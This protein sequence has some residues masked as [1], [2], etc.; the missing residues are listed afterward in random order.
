MSSS[1]IRGDILR[2]RTIE[3][4]T[5]TESQYS[6][7]SHL[8]VHEHA[9]AYFCL[10]LAGKYQE[11]SGR[12]TYLCN[13]GSLVVHPA[14]EKHRNQ[15]DVQ[16]VRC[17][18]LELAGPSALK[19]QE[20]RV[21]SA[22]AVHNGGPSAFAL[23]RIYREFGQQDAAAE[24]IIQGLMLELFG[25]CQRAESGRAAGAVPDSARQCRD[26]LCARFQDR[27]SINEIARCVDVHPVH[28]CRAFYSCYGRTIGEFVRELRVRWAAEQLASA[29]RPLVTI[30]IEAGFCDQSHFN[31][32][33]K[34]FTGMAPGQYRS[35]ITRR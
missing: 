18:N 30:A 9:N 23:T 2:M 11:V 21:L 13:P 31:R 12:R 32:T 29:E 25:E 10:V 8:T 34:R 15:F 4:A 28:L 20:L 27:L 1:Q 33:F 7:G 24:L 19:F 17:F 26:L 6:T 22:P 35:R 14:G 16:P 5:L 3:G